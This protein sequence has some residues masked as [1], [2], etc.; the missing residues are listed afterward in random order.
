M[1]HDLEALKQRSVL[2]LQDVSKSYGAKTV[3]ENI[4][5]AVEPGEFCSL[6]GPS[7][8]GKSTLFRLII[9]EERPNSGELLM[10]GKPVGFPDIS[11]G[12][13][14]QK[15]PLFNHLSVLENV[16]LG[17]KLT[18]DFWQRWFVGGE[19][20][21]EASYYLEEMK[22]ADH[23]DKYPHELS[24]GMQ[25]R[26]AIAQALIMRP[27]ILLM[28]EPF[29]ALDP[30]VREHLQMFLLEKWQKS[31]MTIFFVT[32]DFEEA[33][34]LGTRL[35]V[36][37]QFYTD[38]RG[39]GVLRGARVRVDSPLREIEAPLPANIKSTAKLFE[40][41]IDEIRNAG[42]EPTY[43]QHVKKFSLKHRDSFQTLTEKE[44]HS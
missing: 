6:V 28:D 22:L 19:I 41:L 39:E 14:Y 5:L 43:L 10:A 2:Y 23:K 36:L 29:G 38:D 24:G 12:I 30:N 15:Y 42:F 13:V 18:A 26:V 16:V 7:G 9:G 44:A 11:R 35:L 33:V 1:E 8:C 3:L 20:L 4:D 37:S 32:H 25:Q 40:Q 27:K 34:F 21:D 31:K 17:K